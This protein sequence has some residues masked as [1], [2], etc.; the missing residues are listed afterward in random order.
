MAETEHKTAEEIEILDP[1]REVTIAGETV[2]VR[3]FRYAEGMYLV[4]MIQ[5]ILAR[6]QAFVQGERDPDDFEIYE[7]LVAEYPDEILEL[8]AKACDRPREWVEQLSDEDGYRLQQAFWAAN[9]RFFMRRLMLSSPRIRA[10]A[11]SRAEEAGDGSASA[12][13]PS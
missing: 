11:A 6:L 4:G 9:T 5:P 7:E 12:S 10:A 13:S 2:V 8:M 3:E 1:D